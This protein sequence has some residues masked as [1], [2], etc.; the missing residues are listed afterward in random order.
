[1]KYGTTVGCDFDSRFLDLVVSGFSV[2]L[3][4]QRVS[5]K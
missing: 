2:F 4:S 1:M 3:F 5:E